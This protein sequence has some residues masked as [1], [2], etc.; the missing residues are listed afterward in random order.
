MLF[1]GGVGY[2]QA[3]G[4]AEAETAARIA[5][6]DYGRPLTWTESESRDTRENASHSTAILKG[7]GITE[8]LLVTHGWHMRRAVR[9]FEQEAQRSGSGIQVVA[10]P[11]GLAAS[12]EGALLR[13]MPSLP[14]MTRVRHVL[15]EGL[16]LLF[17]A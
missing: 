15:R 2:G 4:A 3:V 8:I 7:A 1:S 12:S 17:G 16:G 6:R 14:G 9:A 11:M 5:E 10:A 13:W